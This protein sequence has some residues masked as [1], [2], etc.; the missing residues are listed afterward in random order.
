[1]AADELLLN[2]VAEKRDFVSLR[3][4]KWQKPTLS[5]GHNQKPEEII[6]P[7]KVKAA[8]FSAVKRKSGGKMLLHDKEYTF[9][10]GMTR[11]FILEK[12]KPESSITFLEMFKFAMTPLL[13]GL[14]LSGIPVYFADRTDKPDRSHIHCY[15]EAAGHSIFAKG[16]KLIGAAALYSG[17]TLFIHGAI[18]LKSTPLPPNIFINPQSECEDIPMA[19]LNE[20]L[21]AEEI[22]NV[23]QNI[24]QAFGEELLLNLF[25]EPFTEDES[26][27]VESMS[28][29]YIFC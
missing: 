17:K 28:K 22:I 4:Y 26:K 27:K 8:G 18:P 24:A 5:F 3:F 20:F 13:K 21:S 19:S 6:L 23:P 29:K 2:K 10:I 1:M 9:S 12:I 14:Q 7:E 15:T 16:K 11:E 25:P